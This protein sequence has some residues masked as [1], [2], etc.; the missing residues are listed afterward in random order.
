M[1]SGASRECDVC[2]NNRGSTGGARVLTPAA[3]GL[4]F[5]GGA[6]ERTGHGEAH[7]VDGGDAQG[8]VDRLVRR[9]ARGLD[10]DRSALRHGG[11][12]LLHDRHPRTE[13]AAA[14]R[15]VLELARPARTPLRRP[16][17]VVAGVPRRRGPLPGGHRRQR[18]ADLAAHPGRPP[19]DRVRRHRARRGVALR[20][21][22][23]DLRARAGALGPPAPTRVGRRLRRPGVPHDPAAP[24]RRR[25]GDRRD[26]DRRRLP[27]RRRRR[28]LVAAQPGHPGRVPARRASS[29]PSSASACTR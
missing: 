17:R 25:L 15:C 27:D 18:R 8:A 9:G 4:M 12:L 5:L 20:R 29:T 14:R 13:T 11:G 16:R 3:I 1:E 19:G 7:G 26:L 6:G 2:V 10:L 23:R 21:P 22:R 28:V 24:D